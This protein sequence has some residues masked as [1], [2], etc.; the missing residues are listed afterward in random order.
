MNQENMKDIREKCEDPK[1]LLFVK[2]RENDKKEEL[3]TQKIV[4]LH[5]WADSS[6]F[7][8]FLIVFAAILNTVFFWMA[9]FLPD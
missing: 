3:I 6:K 8:R 2:L 4:E 1:N 5:N 9:F 7:D